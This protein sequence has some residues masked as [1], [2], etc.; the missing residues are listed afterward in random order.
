[1]HL[2]RSA[3]PMS[4]RRTRSRTSSGV[5]TTPKRRSVGQRD[6]VR[7]PDDV[8]AAPR[9]GD[10]RAGALHPRSLR[11]RP[12]RSC[13]AAHSPRTRGT[14]PRSRTVVKPASSVTRALRTRRSASCAAEVVV[15]GTPAVWTS[16]TRWLWVSMNPGRTV[17]SPRST[18]RASSG[19]PSPGSGDRLD[20]R[21]AHE[22][23]ARSEES[24][25]TRRPAGG[26]RG[27]R[28]CPDASEKGAGFVIAES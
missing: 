1:M 16:P 4:R 17:R 18:T 26:R 23:R 27:W 20:A 24:R 28:G 10:E 21:V 3:P 12:R 22:E 25:R 6:V 9:C 13:R 11:A 5:V 2:M 14:C 15:A 19:T 7:E 8:A